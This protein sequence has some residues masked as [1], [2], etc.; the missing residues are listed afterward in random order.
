MAGR[1]V[2]D[3]ILELEKLYDAKSKTLKNSAESLR[4][5]PTSFF[6]LVVETHRLIFVPEHRG[7]PTLK[8][9][10]SVMRRFL[11]E[12]FIAHY[13]KVPDKKL[14]AEG[15]SKQTPSPEL[16]IVPMM[17]TGSLV[18]FLDRFELIQNLTIRV[19]EVNN[20]FDNSELIKDLRESHRRMQSKQTE[21]KYKNTSDGLVRDEVSAE[22]EAVGKGTGHVNVIGRDSSGRRIEGNNDHFG[23]KSE[24]DEIPDEIISATDVV[25]REFDNLIQTGAIDRGH[26]TAKNRAKVKIAF[27]SME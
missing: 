17:S 7:S 4:S 24:V 23:V 3:T 14:S 16:E 12:A 1:L 6:A 15:P 8:A 26:S 13:G 2:K 25:M 19:A 10:E 21:L 18:A 11:L 27:E 5:S 9:F 22:L 20:E